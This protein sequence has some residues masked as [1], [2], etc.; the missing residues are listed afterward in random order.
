MK[1]LRNLV[2]VLAVLLT[3]CA[4]G[5]RGTTYEVKS[6]ADGPSS[7]FGVVFG[8]I[9]EGNGLWFRSKSDPSREILHIGGKTAFALQLPAGQY[10]LYQMG[11]PTGRM[12]TNRPLQFTVGD[13]ALQYIGSLIPNWSNAGVSRFPG[14][15]VEERTHIVN[16]VMWSNSGSIGISQPIFS[17]SVA[18]YLTGAAAD[19]RH[20]YPRLPLEKATIG[21]VH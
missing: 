5:V 4:A 7:G 9:C 15:C 11:S 10:E 18:N 13:G 21:I 8:R 3:G 6:D 2:L 16:T 12:V 19:V 20:E 17:I 1:R 14:A